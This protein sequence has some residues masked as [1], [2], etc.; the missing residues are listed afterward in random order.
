MQAFM[1]VLQVEEVFSV[2]REMIWVLLVFTIQ[3]SIP[4]E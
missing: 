3:R 4:G 1:S 2:S